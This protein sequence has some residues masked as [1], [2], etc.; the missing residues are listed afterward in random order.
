MVLMF[1]RTQRVNAGD[2]SCSND[3]DLPLT[4]DATTN[5]DMGNVTSNKSY[6]SII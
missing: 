6:L 3:L 2:V 1:L 4:S 5:E